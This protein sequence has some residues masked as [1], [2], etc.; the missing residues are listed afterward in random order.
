VEASLIMA[1]SLYRLID[2]EM[3]Y[4]GPWRLQIEE[5]EIP[6]GGTFAILGPNGAGKTTLLRLL[7]LLA[8]PQAGKIYL[9]GREVK[10]PSPL[11]LR[12]SLAM[13]FQRPHMLHGS[14]RRNVAFGLRL[15]GERD[16]KRVDEILDRLHLMQLAN[17]PAR[18]LSGGE[19]QRVA[20]ARALVL[21]P[22]V[23][24]LDEPTSNLDPFNARLIEEIIQATV[25]NT[26]MTAIV[27]THNVFQV[28][29]IAD[30]VA[31]MLSGSIIETG[32]KEEI[33]DHPQDDRTRRFVE[34]EMVY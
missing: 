3:G 14:V 10:H 29:R 9:R 27:V 31:M 5:L 34:G 11:N 7:H 21:E 4:E 8:V 25:R 18:R 6:S 30:R 28:K 1:D 2:V 12:R 26:D 32:M 19:I 16:F 20:L 17:M 13:V 33:F 23:L 22:D 15:R 24:L